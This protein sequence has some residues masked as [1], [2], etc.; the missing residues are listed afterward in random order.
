V[1][2]LQG[3]LFCACPLADQCRSPG[4]HPVTTGVWSPRNGLKDATSDLLVV[5]GWYRRM[6]DLGS[7][8]NVAIVPPE[9]LVALDIDDPQSP[10]SA[11][12]LSALSDAPLQATGRVGGGYHVFVSG[13]EG[14]SED[15]NGATVK[16][17]A[18]GYV[19]MTPSDHVSGG[20]YAIIRGGEVLPA[21]PE[22]LK[23]L[24]AR[25]NGAT[26]PAEDG[27][28]L[29]HVAAQAS[30]VD[31][32][33]DGVREGSRYDA[34]RDAV[35]HFRYKLGAEATETAVRDLVSHALK[36][37]WKPAWEPEVFAERFD[38]A[39]KYDIAHPER[40]EAVRKRVAGADEVPQ[41]QVDAQVTE[42][43]FAPGM[44]T[45]PGS[46]PMVVEHLIPRAKVTVFASQPGLGK[47]TARI[48]MGVRLALGSG[49]IFGYYPVPDEAQ[50]VLVL[51]Y[52]NGRHIE[53]ART[54]AVM[55]AVGVDLATLAEKYLVSELPALDLSTKTGRIGLVSL[56]GTLDPAVCFIDSAGLAI[57]QEEWGEKFRATM[58]WL[59]QVA[60][61]TDT[62]LVIVAHLVKA[63]RNQSG[64]R[65][66]GAKGLLDIMG[67][68][69]NFADVTMTMSPLGEDPKRV[70]LEVEKRVVNARLVLKRNKGVW[71]F[72]NAEF[73]PYEGS[74]GVILPA[75]TG[76]MP[77]VRVAGSGIAT[78]SYAAV[79]TQLMGGPVLSYADFKGIT[80]D[81]ARRAVRVLVRQGLVRE[82]PPFSLT[83]SGID[84]ADETF[85]D[86]ELGL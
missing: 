62:A 13:V 28:P 26:E 17:N 85:S 66:T 33:R 56:L 58:Q 69:G 42:S 71:S 68:W 19:V 1:A 51:D 39:W 23:A 46:L 44:M 72:V 63:G 24:K 35:G 75:P 82:G 40:I 27:A 22:V 37:L 31:K 2:R 18:G 38:R 67:S 4:K 7:A 74:V 83:E 81:S 73:G 34:V 47:S 78:G 55:E 41:E 64:N 52:E 76:P 65:V 80:R 49:N 6:D 53:Y 45:D 16:G 70:R 8:A 12:L 32:Y 50:K 79:A 14:M 59:K 15:L 60:V 21:P 48:E 86:P 25:T 20:V 3:V 77:L 5:Q 29:I 54:K 9:G 84:W 11:F 61:D 43:I 10:A 30:W 57:L 36:P